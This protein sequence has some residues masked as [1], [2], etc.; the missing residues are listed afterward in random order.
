[1]QNNPPRM[2]SNRE[3]SKQSSSVHLKRACYIIQNQSNI[4][5]NVF[6]RKN[7]PTVSSFKIPLSS[8]NPSLLSRTKL[9]PCTQSRYLLY[10]SLSPV[11][12]KCT[13]SSW[14]STESRDTIHGTL[15]GNEKR[16]REIERVAREFGVYG[17]AQ[18]APVCS[19]WGE[20]LVLL[21]PR[22]CDPV[23]G[24]RVRATSGSASRY[25]LSG[26]RE[27]NRVFYP[28]F[29]PFALPPD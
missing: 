2:I 16:N 6:A 13:I 11:K 19:R 8:Q 28:Y 5:H 22:A 20:Q 12:I 23:Q 21:P 15:L 29:T 3:V 9:P 25:L 24:R 7:L 14:S 17:G 26:S 10:I 27:T 1:M 4:L 18:L